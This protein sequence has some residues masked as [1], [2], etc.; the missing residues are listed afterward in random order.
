MLTST[1]VQL[2][3]RFTTLKNQAFHYLSTLQSGGQF[4]KC[5]F[6]MSSWSVWKF[7]MCFLLLSFNYLMLCWSL[8]II[9]KNV[10]FLVL[11]FFSIFVI[12]FLLSHVIVKRCAVLRVLFSLFQSLH[13]ILQS[14]FSP[15]C[16]IFPLISSIFARALHECDHIIHL[17]FQQTPS[18][19]GGREES[20]VQCLLASKH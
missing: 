17:S 7:T 6:L 2:H 11:I 1:L 18:Q 14:K 20:T 15:A 3:Q 4:S 8:I 16:F 13:F 10:F 5:L 12:N 19:G 9:S